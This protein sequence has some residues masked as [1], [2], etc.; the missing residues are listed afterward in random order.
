MQA[1]VEKLEKKQNEKPRVVEHQD[2]IRLENSIKS[3]ES[4]QGDIF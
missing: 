2:F 1:N 3:L 4:I